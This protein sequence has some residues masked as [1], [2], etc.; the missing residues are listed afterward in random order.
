[1]GGEVTHM[2]IQIGHDAI[3]C[4]GPRVHSSLVDPNA[5]ADVYHI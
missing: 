5:T 4:T 3:M 2:R 1:M